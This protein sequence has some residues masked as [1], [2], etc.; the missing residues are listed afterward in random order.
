[1]KNQSVDTKLVDGSAKLHALAHAACFEFE[2]IADYVWKSPKLIEAETKLEIEK[3]EAYFPLTGF[4]DEDAKASKLR[5]TRWFFESRKLGNVFPHVMC[6]GN[7][8]TSLSVFEAYVLMICREINECQILSLKSYSGRGIS[9]YWKYLSDVPINLRALAFHEQIVAALALR[10]CLLHAN[11]ILAWLKNP[12]EVRQIVRE[13][14]YWAD[15]TRNKIT[16]EESAD[17]RIIDGSLGE[18]LII[19]NDYAHTVLHYLRFFFVDLCKNAQTAC[20]GECTIELAVRPTY[21]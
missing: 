7:F 6:H 18:Q 12:E 5:A 14:K 10:N 19:S 16:R 17:V 15:Y 20:F 1:M 13:R 21:F 9:K 2:D 4:P 8:F 11:G 3:L